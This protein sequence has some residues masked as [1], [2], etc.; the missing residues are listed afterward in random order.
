MIIAKFVPILGAILFVTGLG[1]LIYTSVW[2]SMDQAMRL[3]VGFFVSIVIIGSAFSFSDKLRYFADVI[4]GGGILLLYGTL[5]YGSR[6][7]DIAIALIPE[8]VT[9]ITA[10][11]FTLAV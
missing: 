1:Y 11:F 2:E 4:M 5:I 10:F 7:T 8:M 9:L 3:G 6:T